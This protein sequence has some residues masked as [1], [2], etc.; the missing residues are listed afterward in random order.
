MKIIQKTSVDY[1]KQSTAKNLI[2]LHY[3]A[4]GTLAGAE[5][6]LA[7]K[8]Y[9]NVHYCIDRDGKIYQYFPEKYWAYHTGTGLADAKRSIGIELVN[10]GHLTRISDVLFSWTDKKIP[11]AQVQRCKPFRGYEYW[12]KLTAEQEASVKWLVWDIKARWKGINVCTHA[13][14]KTTK[15][16]YPPDFPVIKDLIT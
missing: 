9:I 11:W 3:T 1:V 8:D 10:W 13:Q 4:G 14:L 15:L 5:S 7:I 12:Q 16:D 6:T 2:V